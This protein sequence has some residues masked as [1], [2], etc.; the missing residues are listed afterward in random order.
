MALF[1]LFH[2]PGRKKKR[3]VIERYG[4]GYS[5]VP[6]KV[7][8]LLTQ[9]GATESRTGRGD[10]SF[11]RSNATTW[12]INCCLSYDLRCC[13]TA[14]FFSSSREILLFF[15]FLNPYRWWFNALHGYLHACV[16][17]NTHC[18]KSTGGL[19]ME[20]IRAPFFLF[21][22]HKLVQIGS[23]IGFRRIFSP[24]GVS[25][26]VGAI[27]ASKDLFLFRSPPIF[28]Y[29]FIFRIHG[30][31]S[32]PKTRNELCCACGTNCRWINSRSDGWWLYIGRGGGIDNSNNNKKMMKDER[33]Q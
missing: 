4:E 8:K 12:R 29:V 32:S 25:H 24:L 7:T 21:F 22:F 26:Q 2:H 27:W 13:S 1:S 3:F 19:Y 10:W 16:C 15:L 6:R 31:N 28:M 20:N 23:N 9:Y 14:V 33:N 30:D 5:I 17:T 11:A 18:I